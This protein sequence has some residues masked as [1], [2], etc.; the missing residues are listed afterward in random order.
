ME[1]LQQ[2]LM[3]AGCLHSR[4]FTGKSQPRPESDLDRS[5]LRETR[6]HERR[7]K[8]SPCKDMGIRPAVACLEAARVV[9]PAGSLPA[10]TCGKQFLLP[11]KFRAGRARSFT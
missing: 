8:T 9:R 7:A 4:A 11:G 1:I 10:G 5:G 2:G 6:R 3:L